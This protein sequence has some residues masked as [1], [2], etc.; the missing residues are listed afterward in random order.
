MQ[1]QELSK[2]LSSLLISKVKPSLEMFTIELD[3]NRTIYLPGQRIEGHVGLSFNLPTK[4]KLIRVRVSGIIC[5]QVYKN[6][7]AAGNQLSSMVLFKDYVNLGGTGNPEGELIELGPG[8]SVYPFSFRL[9]LTALPA[10]F[11]VF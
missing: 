7:S 4:V 9:P 8:E 3:N 2:R 5:T 10:S 6:S 1:S 11:N